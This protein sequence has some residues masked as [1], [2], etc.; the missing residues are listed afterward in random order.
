MFL[1]HLWTTGTFQTA[2]CRR[3]STN[4][5]PRGTPQY[6]ATKTDQHFG[7]R[8]VPSGLSENINV[9]MC[10]FWAHVEDV[11]S[12]GLVLWC[13]VLWFFVPSPLGGAIFFFCFFPSKRG[14]SL[15]PCWQL[16]SN[17]VFNS[18]F[19]S[20]WCHNDSSENFIRRG[21]KECR[22]QEHNLPR[23]HCYR[24][25]IPNKAV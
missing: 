20:P 6:Y 3:F 5:T 17:I 25:R 19:S 22:F 9:M 8:T 10:D 1:H 4:S 24:Q 11:F 13:C 18:P 12:R 21:F 14:A 2:V 16:C 23:R 7:N 15:T